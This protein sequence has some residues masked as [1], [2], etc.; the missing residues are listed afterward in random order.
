[1]TVCAF[2]ASL[3][4][5]SD[6][7]HGGDAKPCW[8]HHQRALEDLSAIQKGHLWPIC[9]LISGRPESGVRDLNPKNLRMLLPQRFP[10]NGLKF[11]MA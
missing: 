9:I 1:M 8:H 2:R 5:R 6:V 11:T 3:N 7:L 4:L 10:L